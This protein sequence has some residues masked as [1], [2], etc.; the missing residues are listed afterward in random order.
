MIKR[1]YLKAL[2]AVWIGL[3]FAL[4]TVLAQSWALPKDSN[5]WSILTP[6]SDS[7]I[8]Y[9]SSSSGNDSTAQIYST[10]QVGTDPRDPSI[11]VNAYATIG[12]AVSQMRDGYPDWVLLQRGDVWTNVG[13]I[14]LN[15]IGSGR[16]SSERLVI[17]WYGDTG[18][19]PQIQQHDTLFYN[20]QAVRMD[21]W[22]IVGIEKYDIA[23]DPDDANYT[24]GTYSGTTT[25]FTLL[26]GG[27][28]VLIE[29]CKM[30]FS[31]LVMQGVDGNFENV[32]IRRNISTRVYFL[33]SCS[34][35]IRGSNYFLDNVENFLLEENVADYGGWLEGVSTV[36]RTQ[37]NHG[38]YIQYSCGGE[39]I[40]RGNIMSRASGNGG[41]LRSGAIAEMNLTVESPAGYFVDR[42]TQ[43]DPAS[44][45]N[46]AV[47]YNVILDGLW[48]GNCTP[49]SGANWGLTVGD[50]VPAGTDV[51]ENIISGN[52][53]QQGNVRG[54]YLQSSSNNSGN[55]VYDFD[56]NQDMFDSS[57]PDPDRTLGDYYQSIGGTNSTDDFLDAVCDRAINTWPYNF[58]AYAVIDYIRAGFGLSAVGP[59]SGG[60]TVS[61]TGVS[62][63]PSSLSL[64]VNDTAQL[65]EDVVPS[66]A[67][68]QA[69]TWSSNN[70]SVATV[71]SS[72]LVTAVGVG[73]ATITVTTVDGSYT[74]TT[75]VGVSSGT[76]SVTGVSL[77]PTTISLNVSQTAQLTETVS[78]SNATNQAVTWSSNNTSVATVNSSG[79]VSAV[80]VGSATIT[81]TTVD[82]SYTDSTSVSVSSGGGGSSYLL[83]EDTFN[84]SN[85][86][87]LTANLPSG[88][89]GSLVGSGGVDWLEAV[90]NGI[91]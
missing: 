8:M 53:D 69:V 54:T 68:N 70:T 16:N 48:M 50:Q 90:P 45:D 87:D 40:H 31:D 30:N 15:N 88:Q 17:T 24:Y 20:F 67:T 81:V 29:D 63:S 25:M 61:V 26:S 59:G 10:S 77:I 71:N 41:Q 27:T 1:N 49:S 75:A 65:S 82:G 55:I 46:V 85:S 56:P 36:G 60:G 74:D 9:V 72:G 14:N 21:N 58:T 62:V 44:A 76:V 37:Y 86:S 18:D 33:N 23:M 80:G 84:R 57:W 38:F 2:A 28:N 7:R 43:S 6:S 35:D 91:G 4:N 32:E 64:N 34:Q 52:L 83:F 89:T 3:A 11:S 51:I 12:A 13:T 22:A 5:G 39:L 73:T 66:N 78:P 79:L 47:R 42:D 19:R